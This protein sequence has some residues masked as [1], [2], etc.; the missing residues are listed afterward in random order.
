MRLV[1]EKTEAHVFISYSSKDRPFA[2]Q[3]AQDLIHRGVKVWIDTLEMQVGDS[4]NKKIQT[5]ILSSGWLAIILSPHSVSSPWVEKE[6]SAALELELEKRS[7]FV[8]PLLYKDCVIPLF[9]REKIYADFRHSYENG[10]CALLQKIKP[11]LDPQ[12]QNVLT[13][14]SVSAIKAAELQREALQ[15]AQEELTQFKCEFCGSPVVQRDNVPNP[16]DDSD[17]IDVESYA[18]GHS[19]VAGELTCPCPLDSRF[20]KFEEYELQFSPN[21]PG[22]GCHAVPKTKMADMVRIGFG[23]GR[24]KEEAAE[25][26]KRNYLQRASAPRHYGRF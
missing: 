25:C 13:S 7:V 2:E 12:I 21:G 10:L 5:G 1:R 6:L 9:L 14:G 8:L 23:A 20:P 3:I 16:Q 22:W 17:F 15:S 18:C 24:T 4:L 19:I 26:V 11:T